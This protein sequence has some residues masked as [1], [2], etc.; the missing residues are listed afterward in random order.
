M[1]DHDFVNLSV[2]YT[3]YKAACVGKFFPIFIL[4]V[5]QNV[6]LIYLFTEQGSDPITFATFVK[7]HRDFVSQKPSTS[8][9]FSPTITVVPSTSAPI[10]M[11]NLIGASSCSFSNS[12]PANLTSRVGFRDKS[13]RN[14]RMASTTPNSNFIK[15]CYFF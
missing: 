4:V 12:L 15:L 13:L 1:S 9:C 10:N 2:S 11:S 6:L 7:N 3:K 8:A 14:A 5:S